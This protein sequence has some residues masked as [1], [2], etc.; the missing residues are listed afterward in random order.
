VLKLPDSAFRSAID[1]ARGTRPG[2][3]Q[4]RR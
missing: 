4:R 3:V 1:A 2:L